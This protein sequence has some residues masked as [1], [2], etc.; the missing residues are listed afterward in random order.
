MRTRIQHEQDILEAR[1]KA[2]RPH[3]ASGWGVKGLTYFRRWGFS[4]NEG[5]I[6]NIHVSWLL[7][8]S[9]RF[10]FY[11][12]LYGPVRVSFSFPWW[13]NPKQVNG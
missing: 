7:A 9:R 10:Y 4:I 12:A 6:P 2:G 5:A 8:G 3:P 1:T 11:L 13:P